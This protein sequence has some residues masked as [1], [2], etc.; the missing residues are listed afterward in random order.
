MRNAVDPGKYNREIVIEQ[1]TETQSETGDVIETW[2]TLGPD[3]IWAYVQSVSGKRGGWETFTADQVLADIDTLFTIPYRSDITLKMRINYGGALYNIRNTN[4]VG[5][6][7][8][9]EIMAQVVRA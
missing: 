4:E 9:L 2:T 5:Y 6:K 1:V 8:E 3:P 7:V